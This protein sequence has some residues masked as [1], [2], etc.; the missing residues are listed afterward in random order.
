M[1]K[2]SMVKGNPLLVRTSESIGQ[3]FL[4]CSCVVLEECDGC[5]LLVAKPMDLILLVG[6][7]L[8]TSVFLDHSTQFMHFIWGLD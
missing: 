4:Y 5:W 7:S 2:L 8:Q 6:S 1:W 3:M